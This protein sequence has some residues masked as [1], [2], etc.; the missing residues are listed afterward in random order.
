MILSLLSCR[1]VATGFLLMALA[2]AAQTPAGADESARDRERRVE[3]LRQGIHDLEE[4]FPKRYTEA[5]VYLTR[6]AEIESRLRSGDPTGI[7]GPGTSSLRGAACQPTA[8]C[9]ASGS[10]AAGEEPG[11]RRRHPRAPRVEFGTEAHRLRQR[12][13][14]H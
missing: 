14:H 6:L 4:T 10:Q 13:G 2:Q 5:E 3:K 9:V 11:S 12:A 7:G 1:L 8:R